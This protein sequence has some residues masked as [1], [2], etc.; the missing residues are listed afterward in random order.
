M[1]LGRVVRLPVL[2]MKVYG[3]DRVIGALNVMYYTQLCK[4]DDKERKNTE[5][6]AVEAG[7]SGMFDDTSELKMKFKEAMNRLFSNKWKE[8][9]ENEHKRMT[10]S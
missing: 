2:Y 6:S 9:I 8:E 4:L 5:I 1:G 10:W 7:L 3:S